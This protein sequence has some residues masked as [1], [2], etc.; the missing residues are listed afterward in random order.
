MPTPSTIWTGM[1][2]LALEPVDEL[3]G[4][5]D[6]LGHPVDAA[7]EHPADRR[8]QREPVAHG[9]VERANVVARSEDGPDPLAL[10]QQGRPVTAVRTG[11]AMLPDEARLGA[12]DAGPVQE[13]PE[14]GGGAEAS[15]GGGPVAHAETLSQRNLNSLGCP[16]RRGPAGSAD[17]GHNA[18][19]VAPPSGHDCYGEGE[20]EALILGARGWERERLGA[21]DRGA[22]ALSHF[23]IRWVHGDLDRG[24]GPGRGEPGGRGG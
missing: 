17:G 7:R 6:R 20:G 10:E 24:R 21:V 23:R 2:S 14:V 5:A 18:G 11:L 9:H 15:R 4:E 19:I 12:P 8:G 3:L 13:H 22:N 1:E 16:D